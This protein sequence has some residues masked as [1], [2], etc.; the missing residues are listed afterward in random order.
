[1]K[2]KFNLGTNGDQ[3]CFEHSVKKEF[4]TQEESVYAEEQ[5]NSYM[6]ADEMVEVLEEVGEGLD[7]YWDHLREISGGNTG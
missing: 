5:S 3:K 2:K 1:M 4:E 7:Y 6:Q